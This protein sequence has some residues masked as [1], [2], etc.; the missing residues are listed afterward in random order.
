MTSISPDPG[1]SPA[2]RLMLEFLFTH[3]PAT[4]SELQQQLGVSRT[5]LSQIVGKLLG[6]GVLETSGKAEYGTGRNGR[7]TQ[8][9]SIK[10]DLGAAVGIELGRSRT[11][12]TVVALDGRPVDQFSVTVSSD[13]SP[14]VRLSTAVE[15]L[16]DLLQQG[17]LNRAAVLGVGVGIA[18][19]HDS[20]QTE[21][22]DAAVQADP[23]GLSLEPLRAL[24]RSP[25]IWDNN[26][27]MAAV[28]ELAAEG[29]QTTTGTLLYVMLSAGISSGILLDGRIY[30]GTFGAAG[31]LGHICVDPAGPQ[32]W[33]GAIGCLESVL[34]TG[35]VLRVACEAGLGTAS[36]AAL[37]SAIG[38]PDATAVRLAT[39]LGGVLGQALA[40]AAMLLDPQSIVLTGDL[41]QLGE[42]FLAAAAAQLHSRR[43]AVGLPAC[44]I[45]VT[46]YSEH[47]GSLGAAQAA[48]RRWGTEHIARQN[49]SA[50][51]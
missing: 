15:F 24:F 23:E 41:V 20:A 10:A 39:Q 18:T 32:C 30:R 19:R 8:R 46:S 35:A 43:A 3:G 14:G 28:T 40:A 47:A 9:L 13:A 44:E 22:P 12:V 38:A 45:R 11:S 17:R 7:P 25:V 1:T 5:T 27:R 4:R 34:G 51:S 2:E 36:I 49:R 50:P 37:S 31:E 21:R 6:N 33:C 42:P 26:I 29:E 16:A 48:I